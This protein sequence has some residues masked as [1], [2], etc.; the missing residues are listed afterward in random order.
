MKNYNM[1]LLEKQR[2]NQPYHQVKFLKYE[3]LTGEDILPS[4]QQ[5]TIEQAKFTYSP[6]GKVFEKQVKTIGDQVEKQIKAIQ[7]QGKVRTIKKYDYEAEDIP[8]ISKQKEIFSELVDE[9]FEKITDFDK[10]VNS[11]DLIYRY[12]VNIADEKFD[13]FDTALD[14]IDKIRDGKIDLV[15]VKNNQEKFKSYL[16][17]IKRGNKKHRSKV[18][19]NTLYNIEMLYK[20]RKK[21]IKFYDDYSL[22]MSEAKYRAT[23]GIDLKYGHLNKY[24]KDYNSTCTSKSWS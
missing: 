1:I 11:D 15:D 19:K 5:Q 23:K 14:I 3:Y 24:F 2:N 9:R 12:K 13:K 8:F 16:G 17:E 10:K 22:M 7:D 21:A 6:L 4:N 20:A 18:Q